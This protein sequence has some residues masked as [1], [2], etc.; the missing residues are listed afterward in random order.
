MSETQRCRANVAIAGADKASGGN[1]RL[2]TL[3]YPIDPECNPYIRVAV[4]P[5]ACEAAVA[6]RLAR[7]RGREA[8]LAEWLWSHQASLSR[9]SVFGAAYDV[10]GVVDI[11][12]RYE[13]VLQQVR[14]DIEIA[15]TFGVT[16]TPTFFI[17]GRRVP[18]LPREDFATAVQS[19]LTLAGKPGGLD[20]K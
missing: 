4:H 10:A 12:G 17:N 7:E 19:E 14:A 16:R 8:E 5:A 15:H 6:I 11:E 13:E 18:F 1:V 2:A 3:D 20:A 9:A